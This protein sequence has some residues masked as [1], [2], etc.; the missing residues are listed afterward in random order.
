MNQSI[1]SKLMFRFTI[2]ILLIIILL[3]FSLTYFFT[4]YYFQTKQQ[5]FINIGQRIVAVVSQ[6]ALLGSFYFDLAMN[7]I[8]A[9]GS[10]IEQKF[11]ITDR[12]GDILVTNS[13]EQLLGFQIDWE[14]FAQV[15]QGKVIT[16]RGK[17]KYIEEPVMMVAVPI[18]IQE[19]VVAV[20]FVYNTIAGISGTIQE[21]RQILFFIGIFVLILAVFLSFQFSRSISKPIQKIGSASIA[22]ANGNYDVEVEVKMEDEIG[23]LASNFNFLVKKLRKHLQ[24][25]REFVANVS[26]EL[27]TPLTSIRGYVKALRDG[28]FEDENS[29]QEYCNIIMD[30]TDRMN[31]LVAE[32][33]SLS[34]IESGILK[35]NMIAF[36]LDEL[37]QRTISSLRPILRKGGVKV[38]IEL[39][40]F[41]PQVWGDPDRI[42]QVFINLIRNAIKHS[43]PGSQIWIRAIQENKS[44]MINIEIEDQG[45][46]I[47]EEE[48]EKIWDRFYKVDKARTRGDEEGT[49]LGLAIVKEIIQRHRGEVYVR[50]Q[51]GKGSVFGFIVKS[52]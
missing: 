13:N 32:L 2:I 28:I 47:P 18:E 9:S 46:G 36:D 40:D 1:F 37:V 48:L 7:Q 50:S 42:G 30:E 29:P 15:L 20:V 5:E 4:E 34:Q 41:L 25:Q 27:K 3:S 31:R 22:M 12:Q 10:L 43:E 44:K 6:S 14:T 8:Q 16:F 49:G 19:K 11:W 51:F 24:L 33:L 26:H 38:N 17:L 39:P 23:Q 35:F 21:L 45:T 52:V